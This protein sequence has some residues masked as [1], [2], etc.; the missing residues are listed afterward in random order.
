MA[1]V[2]SPVGA[3]VLGRNRDGEA[4]GRGRAPLLWWS[5]QGSTPVVVWAGLHSCGGLGRARVIES[6]SR[7]MALPS[8]PSRNLNPT[9][10]GNA[11]H[12]DG[13]D[14]GIW[15]LGFLGCLSEARGLG[16]A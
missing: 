11:G 3:M 2:A 16:L 14:L 5:G 15:D 8:G 13:D 10:A 1:L 9:F 12:G 6:G 4:R 7:G